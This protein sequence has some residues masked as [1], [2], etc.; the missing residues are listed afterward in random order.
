MFLLVLNLTLFTFN[1]VMILFQGK[2][3][4]LKMPLDVFV[5]GS[6]GDL[7]PGEDVGTENAIIVID[8]SR[9]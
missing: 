3:W 2:T 6:R 9:I 5:S 7:V 1:N 4:G 8:L